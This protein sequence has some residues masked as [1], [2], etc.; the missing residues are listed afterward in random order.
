MNVCCALRPVRRPYAV[1]RVSTCYGF[2]GLFVGGCSTVPVPHRSGDERTRTPSLAVHR[3]VTRVA[4]DPDLC[5]S[6]SLSHP[7][8]VI[9]VGRIPVA[10]DLL[11][12]SRSPSL[13]PLVHLLSYSP[14][15]SFTFAHTLNPRSPGRMPVA[16]DLVQT[17]RSPS[18]MPNR[19]FIMLFKPPPHMLSK[20]SAQTSSYA[21]Q[22]LRSSSYAL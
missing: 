7:S 19:S 17:A 2:I 14:N 12:T 15:L 8:L 5:R 9:S 6:A 4:R 11:Q 18:L 10:H 21:V 13:I 16:H 20:S 1:N 3:S 22:T